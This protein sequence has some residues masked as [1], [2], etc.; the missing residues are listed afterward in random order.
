[1]SGKQAS[2]AADAT[3]R[4]LSKWM[5]QAKGDWNAQAEALPL[6]RDMVT[7]LTYLHENRV[8]GTRSTGN[9][10][11]KAVREVTAR[12][13]NPPQLDT[14]IGDRTYRLRSEDDVWSL[15]F[16]HTLA[17]MGRLLEGGPA[18]PWIVT[19]D[20]AQFLAASPLVQVWVLL[21]TWWQGVDWL[22]AYPFEGMGESLPPRFEEITLAHLLSLPVSKRIPFEPFA[23]KLIEETRLKWTAPDMSGAQMLLHGAVE[24]MVIDILADFGAVE[25]EYRDKPLGKGTIKELVAFQI[26]S[27]GRGLLESLQA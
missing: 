26:T 4:R 23:D 8:K 10:P 16:L 24:R 27:L 5:R 14:T 3:A 6:R 12:F 21:V 20:G 9:L 19:R 7:L 22:I 1:M 2:K 18:Q 11:L 15:S 25:R 13:V 17:Y